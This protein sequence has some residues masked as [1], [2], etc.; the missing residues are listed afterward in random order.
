LSRIEL[1]ERAERKD[2]IANAGC[3]CN[4]RAE[5]FGERPAGA[6]IGAQHYR[7][8][9]GV[10]KISHLL[11]PSFTFVRSRCLSEIAGPDQP[12]AELAEM[13]VLSNG[14]KPWKLP[15]L[16]ATRTKDWDSREIN[17]KFS[18]SRHDATGA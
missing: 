5:V 13:G 16:T 18:A 11:S 6:I 15:A 7:R 2:I 10:S 12:L 9:S 4:R 1:L 8:I 3:H 17:T 14:G